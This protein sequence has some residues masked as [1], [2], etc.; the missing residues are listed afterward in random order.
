MKKMKKCLKWQS[1]LH[2]LLAVPVGPVDFDEIS[3]HGESTV[4]HLRYLARSLYQV[5]LS[6]PSRPLV[7]PELVQQQLTV[8]HF[9]HHLPALALA[10]S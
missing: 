8:P 4:H 5:V 3:G 7:L 10:L 9:H 6:L 1:D 2:L